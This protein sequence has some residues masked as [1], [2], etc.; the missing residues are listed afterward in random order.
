M[1]ERI[2]EVFGK[3]MRFKKED[4]QLIVFDFDGV[5][6]DNRVLLC[7][8]GLESVVVNRADGL[9]VKILRELG[10]PMLILSTE[11]NRVVSVR[12]QKLQIPV[13]QNI[14]DKAEALTKYCAK[15]HI[16]MSGVMFIGND[17]NDLEVMKLVGIRVVPSDAH[18]SVK[19]IADT[20]LLSPGG[21][22]VVRELADLFEGI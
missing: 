18:P 20:I 1:P 19:K 3:K 6:T 15:R 2:Y 22:G 13:L 21:G 17:L 11:T 4:V 7:E 5:M 16:D 12:G 10:F 14:P 8:N 9:G